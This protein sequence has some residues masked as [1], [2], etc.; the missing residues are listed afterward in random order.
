MLTEWPHKAQKSQNREELLGVV[1]LWR[2]SP[3]RESGLA[4]A[5]AG[6][7]ASP[8][9]VK[10]ANADLTMTV[11]GVRGEEVLGAAAFSPNFRGLG[12]GA[13]TFKQV[14]D[15]EA[16]LIRF[17]RDVIVEF[18]SVVAGNG[19]CGGF[20]RVGDGAPLAIYCVDADNDSKEQHGVL[21]DIGVL[22]AGR[23]LR[24][25]SRSHLGVEP[26]GR[27]RLGAL[28]VRALGK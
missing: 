17:N 15:G 9:S 28:S 10:A 6:R 23:T 13:G 12:I 16:L 7:S 2:V 21:G 26:P 18:A 5:L 25:D 22:K 14:D 24:L 1:S 3:E 20:Y 19:Q 27:W 4:K 11:T 8:F